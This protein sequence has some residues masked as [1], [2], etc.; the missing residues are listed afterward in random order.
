MTSR[1]R[2]PIAGFVIAACLALTACGGDDDDASTG[3]ST[4]TGSATTQQAKG[5]PI[6]V[7]FMIPGVGTGVVFPY[8]T[9]AA[10]AAVSYINDELGG[11]E[12]RPIDLI[13]CES[14]GTPESDAKCA[15]DVMREKPLVLNL[16][17]VFNMAG[18]YRAQEAAGVPIIGAIPTTP[19]DYTAKNTVW[20]SAG[21]PGYLSTHGKWVADHLKPKKVAF[22][23]DNPAAAAGLKLMA[24]DIEASGATVSSHLVDPKESDWL[25]V[26]KSVESDDPDLVFGLIGAESTCIGIAKARKTQ[27]SDVL[28][29]ATPTC[30]GDSVF[31]ATGDAMDG[32]YI[33]YANHELE[34]PEPSEEF[35]IYKRLIDE[36]AGG[37]QDADSNTTFSTIMTTYDILK[38]VAQ[39]DGVDNI[40]SEAIY[41]KA[42]SE[43]G[44]V[45]M[46]GEYDCSKA[47][48]D[49]PTQCVTLF[50]V[51]KVVGPGKLELAEAGDLFYYDQDR[52][53]V[54]LAQ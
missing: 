26:W 3:A 13:A 24:A 54:S 34:T 12:G 40:T 5:E 39:E 29:H 19:P 42:T 20:L 25:S 50:S 22:V 53:Q 18:V 30:I 44:K 37:K 45:W 16:A 21:T 38:R 46:G 41:K 14:E 32:W 11:V 17:E 36:K 4:E 23:Y 8:A 31:K 48:K 49:A 52:K 28:V 6:K 33:G 35:K 10:K 1:V 43:P 27:R 47:P 9:D 15:Q 51:Y 2:I 7:G